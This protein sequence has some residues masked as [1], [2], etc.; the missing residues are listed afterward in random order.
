MLARKRLWNPKYPIC[1]Q[2]A[3]KANSQGDGGRRLEESRGD[4]L[5][6]EPTS[7]KQTSSKHIHDFPS[8][9]YLF[10][11]TGREKE[12]W[13]RHFLLASRDAQGE[14]ERDR[15]KPGK[16]VSRSGMRHI[17]SALEKASR[18]HS[19]TSAI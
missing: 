6:A 1:I 9:L 17:T 18:E 15:Q 12:E 19:Y 8:T 16:C 14:T 3:G 10:G 2:L 5:E 7:P 4:E 11:R 13:F